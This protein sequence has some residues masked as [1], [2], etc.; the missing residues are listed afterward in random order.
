MKR[1]FASNHFL[2]R[3]KVQ[4]IEY[5]VHARPSSSWARNLP[6]TSHINSPSIPVLTSTCQYVSVVAEGREEGYPAYLLHTGEGEGV[7]VHSYVLPIL[8]NDTETSFGI[9]SFLFATSCITFVS[10]Y[11]HHVLKSFSSQGGDLVPPVE[12]ISFP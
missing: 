8:L 11:V 3:F 2:Y 12:V 7:V 9:R 6:P 10:D 1:T 5:G 4:Y